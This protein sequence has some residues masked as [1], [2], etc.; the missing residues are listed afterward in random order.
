MKMKA[1]LTAH[2]SLLTL[3]LASIVGAPAHAQTAT[4]AATPGEQPGDEPAADEQ[5]GLG[6]IVVTAQKRSESLQ[7]T[8]LAISAVSEEMIEARGIATAEDLNAVAPNLTTTQGPNNSSHLI[9]FIRGIGESEPILT[10]DA[11]VAIYVD[12]V[13][14]GR[15]TQG[16][17]D[18]VDLERVEVLRGP[19]GTLYGRNTTGGAV[20][21]ITKK[22]SKD[23]GVNVF[24]SAG[25]LGFLQARVSVDTGDL[26][27]SGFRAKFSY[28]HKQ[29][30]GYLDDINAPDRRDPGA[31]NNE[32]YRVALAFDNGGPFRG[33]YTFDRNESDAYSPGTQLAAARADIVSYFSRSGAVGG[34]PF[35]GPNQDRYAQTRPDLTPITDRNQSH[36]LT[37]ELDLGP[38]NVLRSISGFRKSMN[39]IA[40]TDLD[41]NSGLRGLVVSPAPPGIQ[42]IQL[43]GADKLTKQ[44]QFSQ[45]LNLIGNF[46]DTLDY[47]IGGYYFKERAREAN[48]QRF[49][50]VLNI[51]GLGLAGA[52]IANDLIYRHISETKA[53]FG[54]ATYHI[55]EDLDF[56]GGVRYTEDKKNLIQ[57][58]PIVRDITREFSN[59][60]FAGTLNYQFTPSIF[61][62]ARVATGYKA[63]GFNARSVNEG[64]DPEKVTSYETGIKSDFFNRRLRVNAN[65]FLAKL[66]DKQ[67]QQ[68][69]AGSGGASSITVNAGSATFKGVELE[70]E[71]LPVEQL[72][73]NASFGHTDREYDTFTVLDPA[74]NMFVD[75]AGEAQFSYTA[76]TTVTAGAEYSFGNVLSGE[77]SARVDYSYRSRIVFNVIPRFSPF[78]AAIASPAVGLFDARLSLS[79]LAIAGR[80]SSIALWGRNLSDK[81]YR[82]SGIDFGALGFATNTYS[83]GR[84]YG[85]DLKIQF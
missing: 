70:I 17:F 66:K 1:R 80:E 20:N 69:R 2:A 31:Y 84:T 36:A 46:G 61:G 35:L 21:L 8:P 54:Q 19:Q 82:V 43:F 37:L 29:R 64:F 24:A 71:A 49:T 3:G 85:V 57:A 73:L 13:I 75:I 50:F 40:R 26:G 32:A 5:G 6:E 12:G 25:N 45:E 79:G 41:G 34:T 77:L 9:I 56:T 62:Y 4:D 11:P 28:L 76:K 68:F 72:R 51:P 78:D 74:S 67:T 59:T 18:L 14:V 16:I 33:N 15:S 53:A 27:G 7:R 30:Q 38:D 23:F 55:T 22:P 42:P 83:E 47:V 10:V 48:P 65:L 44:R 63:G 81:E 60:N 58:S 52:N 39:F